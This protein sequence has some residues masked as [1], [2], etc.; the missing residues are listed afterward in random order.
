MRYAAPSVSRLLR[1]PFCTARV[2]CALMPL[3]FWTVRVRFSR[4]LHFSFGSVFSSAFAM[5]RQ[6]GNGVFAAVSP[7]SG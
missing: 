2:I 5:Q 3:S 6:D 4:P 1:T 7:A